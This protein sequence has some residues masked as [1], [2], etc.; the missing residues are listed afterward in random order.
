MC[1]RGTVRVSAVVHTPVIRVCRIVSFYFLGLLISGSW[2]TNRGH[3]RDTLEYIKPGTPTFTLPKGRQAGTHAFLYISPFR[4][5]VFFYFITNNASMQ[6]L[7]SRVPP[8][9]LPPPPSLPSS[10]CLPTPQ[11]AEQ[12]A[13]LWSP[14]PIWWRTDGKCGCRS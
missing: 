3:L 13:C 1:F 2:S 9:S 5:V 10:W 11:L 12:G 8:H 7:V 6:R 14:M 4:S